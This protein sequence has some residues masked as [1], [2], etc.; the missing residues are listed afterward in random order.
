M[1]LCAAVLCGLKCQTI[2]NDGGK[3]QNRN[4]EGNGSEDAV[5]HGVV[6]VVG[7]PDRSG[8]ANGNEAAS[9]NNLKKWVVAILDAVAT[10]SVNVLCANPMDNDAWEW[11]QLKPDPSSAFNVE[12]EARRLEQTPNAG[13]I[14]AQLFRAWNMQQ[15]LLQQA[16]NRIAALELQ[17]MERDRQAGT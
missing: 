5:F 17:I 13:P 4:G 8:Q 9:E 12:K 7:Y 14:A 16:T 15:T 2:V 1:L 10:P 3:D 11:M 6:W